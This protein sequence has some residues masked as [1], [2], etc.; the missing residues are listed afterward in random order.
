MKTLG[1]ELPHEILRCRELLKNYD[2]IG[3]VGLFAKAMILN[4]ITLA[5]KAILEGDVVK[6]IH[7]FKILQAC[8]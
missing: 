4:D 6:M 3:H 1:T 8:E 5:E 2:A 7:Y